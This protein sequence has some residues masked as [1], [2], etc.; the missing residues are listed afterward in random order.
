MK[1]T[2]EMRARLRELSQPEGDDYDRAVVMVLDDLDARVQFASLTA[3]AMVALFTV[4]N[5]AEA[6][7]KGKMPEKI[8]KLVDV[9]SAKAMQVA[10]KYELPHDTVRQ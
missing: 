5:W 7:G 4:K 6:D 3:D 1:S 8:A 2:P 10:E 9:V